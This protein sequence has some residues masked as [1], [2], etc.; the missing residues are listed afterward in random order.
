MLNKIGLPQISRN[1]YIGVKI[2]PVRLCICL[3]TKLILFVCQMI[4]K[5]LQNGVGN[6]DKT[7]LLTRKLSVLIR[8]KE[9][10]FTVK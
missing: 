5:F 8:L 9:F 4:Q 1:G 10:M 6:L 2:K 7:C 3:L